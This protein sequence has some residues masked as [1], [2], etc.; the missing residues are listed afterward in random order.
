MT[1]RPVGDLRPGNRFMH[2]GAFYTARR[3]PVKVDRGWTVA[4]END[5]GQGM[6]LPF[7][8]GDSLGV[9]L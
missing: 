3:G 8:D 5:D 2:D 4:V 7:K 6:E 1:I 9:V